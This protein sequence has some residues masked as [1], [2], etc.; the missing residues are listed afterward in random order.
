[1]PPYLIGQNNPDAASP[2]YDPRQGPGGVFATWLQG[3]TPKYAKN[4]GSGRGDFF[5]DTMARI[6]IRVTRADRDLFEGTVSDLH[7]RNRLLPR[8][9]GDVGH[10]IG[11]MDFLLQGMSMTFREKI[12]LAETLGDNYVL[13]TFGQAA[14][15]ITFQGVL[16]NTAQD[17][18]AQNFVR[19]YLELLRA[20]QL[21]RRQKAASIEVDSY[22]FTGAMTELNINLGAQI[23]TI[24]PFSFSFLVKKIAFTTYTRGWSPGRVGTVFS[25]DPRAF[26]VDVRFAREQAATAVTLATPPDTERTDLVRN[27][28]QVTTDASPAEGSGDGSRAEDP[29]V[30]FGPPISGGAAGP[31]GTPQTTRE[32]SQPVVPSVRDVPTTQQGRSSQQV[33]TTTTS[34]RAPTPT[35]SSTPLLGPRVLA[36]TPATSANPARPTPSPLRTPETQRYSFEEPLF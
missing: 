34:A 17:D 3:Q 35:R 2:E 22:I 21:A 30:M 19:L 32:T 20:T 9:I 15:S 25:N 8:L 33:P 24:V 31:T 12:Q 27:D 29:R 23:E 7:V 14:P 16:I 28:E 13:Y 6:A 36:P 26:P 18:Q 5:R 11:Y 1:M 4:D 10:T